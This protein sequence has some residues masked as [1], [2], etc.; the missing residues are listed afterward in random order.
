MVDPAIMRNVA[1]D[2]NLLT[3]T[4]RTTCILPLHDQSRVLVLSCGEVSSSSELDKVVHQ[5]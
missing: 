3:L 5:H 1:T 4:D 2:A